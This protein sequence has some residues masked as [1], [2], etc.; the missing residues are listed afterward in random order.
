MNT[1]IKKYAIILILLINY[2]CK[3]FN[4]NLF[5]AGSHAYSE[6]YTVNL[7][8]KET[9][10]KIKKIKGKDK[11]LQVPPFLWV[12][13][14]IMLEDK[15]SENNNSFIFYI[16]FKERDQI[17]TFYVREKGSS[18]SIV[19][20]DAVHNGLSLGNWKNVNEDLSENENK[21]TIKLFEEKII[22][23]LN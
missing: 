22:S 14:T 4:I 1:A 10:K 3:D 21:E 2:S 11:D 16:Y 12:R 9:I 18:Q 19:G 7:S 8:E 5:S 23:K 20:L 15:F 13:D 17:A 6:K